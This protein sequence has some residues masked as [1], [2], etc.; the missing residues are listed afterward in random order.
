MRVAVE[1]ELRDL[2][3][4]ARSSVEDCAAT[5][6][7]FVAADRSGGGDAA[8]ELDRFPRRGVCSRAVRRGCHPCCAVE[9]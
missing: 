5:E 6:A 9:E 1:E 7:I 4:A 8:D 3:I 2:H